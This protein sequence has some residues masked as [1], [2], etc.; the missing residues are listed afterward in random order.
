MKVWVYREK[1]NEIRFFDVDATWLD[2]ERFELIGTTNMVIEQPKKTV[3][4]EIC[5]YLP[6]S[7]SSIYY[8][9]EIR[10]ECCIPSHAKNIKVTYEVEE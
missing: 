1:N 6:S 3:K 2:K 7:V 9:D 4:K 10:T 5:G 8:H